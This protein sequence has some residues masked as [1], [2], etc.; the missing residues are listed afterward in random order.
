MSAATLE[1]T[2]KVNKKSIGLD[3]LALPEVPDYFKTVV[4][5]KSKTTVML[6]SWA[7]KSKSVSTSV[8]VTFNTE[9]LSFDRLKVTYE[10]PKPFI[11]GVKR[12]PENVNYTGSFVIQLKVRPSKFYEITGYSVVADNSPM[13]QYLKSECL[14]SIRSGKKFIKQKTSAVDTLYKEMFYGHHKAIKQYKNQPFKLV[15]NR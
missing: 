8:L 13:M 14:T 3:S 4:N 9:F 7:K 11:K 2:K 5:K 6:N 15:I 12:K 1:P 10:V